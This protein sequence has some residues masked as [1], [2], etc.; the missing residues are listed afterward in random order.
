MASLEA[1]GRDLASAT[2]DDLSPHTLFEPEDLEVID[3]G[4]SVGR[5]LSPGG[6]S[7]ASVHHQIAALRRRLSL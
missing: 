1:D 6:G 7:V 2:A 3:P 5:R 4:E